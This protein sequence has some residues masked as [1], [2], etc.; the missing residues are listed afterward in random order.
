M[1]WVKRESPAPG[2]TGNGT[3]FIAVNQ[4]D[5]VIRTSAYS[6]IRIFI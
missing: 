1:G 4:H 3:K 2:L 6:H 5:D